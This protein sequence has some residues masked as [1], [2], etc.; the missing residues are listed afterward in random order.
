MRLLYLK[1]L[2]NIENTMIQKQD[3]HEL[4]LQEIANKNTQE[5]AIWCESNNLPHFHTWT[6]A[7][8]VAEFGSW[9]LVKSDG[10][11]DCLATL[12][13]NCGS[14][15]WRS[16]LW[17]LTRV[18]RSSLLTT[19]V[20]APDYGAFTP[21]ILMGFKRMQG[22]DYEAWRNAIGLEHIL[23]PDLYNAVFLEDYAC[24][25][26]GSDRLLEL[27]RQGCLVNSG[28][29]K[30]T[31]K[32]PESTWSLSNL[33]DTELYSVPKLTQTMLT[34]CWLAHPK[35]RTP[36]MI[37]DPQNWDRMPEPLVS[38]DIFITPTQPKR[39]VVEDTTGDLP[40]N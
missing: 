32:N 20:K 8:M 17:K 28:P 38:S 26:L 2:K 9:R 34:Q 12:K 3:I 11:V 1:L 14:D 5:A 27:R 22:I 13:H 39:L 29:K 25:N 30:G 16:G 10:V 33:K 7:Q 15:L 6:L 23:E 31:Y 4:K 21:L 36:Y 40:W 37:L 24:C 18:K 19:Q 35:H